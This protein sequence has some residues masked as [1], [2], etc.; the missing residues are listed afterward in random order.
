[1]F[2]AA[3]GKYVE[4]SQ[5]YFLGD[6]EWSFLQKNVKS[7]FTKYII[8]YSS[9]QKTYLASKSEWKSEWKLVFKKGNI[10]PYTYCQNQVMTQLNILHYYC[11]HFVWR[12][13]IIRLLLFY[14]VNSLNFL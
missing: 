14:S 9:E 1:M 2:L 10:M 12:P 3:S 8:L 6:I 5:A 7:V 4:M 11:F 13:K